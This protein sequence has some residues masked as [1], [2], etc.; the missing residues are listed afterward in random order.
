MQ[1]LISA[2]FL[3]IS[4]LVSPILVTLFF[5]I[6]LRLTIKLHKYSLSIIK[7]ALISFPIVLFYPGT[8]PDNGTMGPVLNY[9]LFNISRSV[10]NNFG[11]GW[12]HDLNLIFI[13]TATAFATLMFFIFYP[14]KSKR[15]MYAL[16]IS[17][18][19]AF[20]MMFLAY[21][22]NYISLF[23]YVAIYIFLGGPFD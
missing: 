13:F 6:F 21:F 7:I 22:S 18:L 1:I 12:Y 11:M 15:V 2:I 23:I 10:F 17:I 8:G 5:L 9:I 20:V 4:V 16:L 14:N 19:F 3:I